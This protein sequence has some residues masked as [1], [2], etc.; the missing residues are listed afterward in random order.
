MNVLLWGLP[1]DAPLAAIRRELLR[2]GIEPLT[3]DQRRPEQTSVE[4]ITAATVTGT[5]RLPGRTIAIQD[6][7]AAYLRPYDAQRL[8]GTANSHA[9]A[10]AEALIAWTGVTPALVVNRP[11]AMA[12]NESK[13]Y[14]LELIRAAGF[15]VPPTLVT[16]DP[17]AVRQFASEHGPLIYKSVSGV[18]SRVARLSNERAQSLDDVAWCPTQLQR[19]IDGVDHRVHVV[20]DA[21]FATRV[22]SAADDYRYAERAPTLTETTLPPGIERRAIKLAAALDLPLAGIDLRLTPDGDWVCFEVNPSPAFTYYE[23]ATGQPIAAAIA[24]L[25]TG[26]G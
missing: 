25:L 24:R 14:Q 11:S 22:E 21:V 12:S 16:T 3:I 17:A 13:P 15:A 18:R 4:L 9:A 19:H 2:A 7:D 8:H 1:Q 20:K 6:I 10:V 26:A 23:S 5:L